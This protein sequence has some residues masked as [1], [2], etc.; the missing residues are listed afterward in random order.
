MDIPNERTDEQAT[1][2]QPRDRSQTPDRPPADEQY[3]ARVAM[4]NRSR[5]AE[6]PEVHD[7]F[8]TTTAEVDP[9][10]TGDP[11]G[12]PPDTRPTGPRSLP[13]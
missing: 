12:S 5:N 10:A 6:W 3:D 11:I 2:Q 8:D 9:R 13:G 1:P 7:P 4:G